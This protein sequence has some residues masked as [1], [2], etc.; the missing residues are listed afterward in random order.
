M[1]TTES[2]KK[3][4]FAP[5]DIIISEAE[6]YYASFPVPW[7]DN[8]E[9]AHL[10]AKE[11]VRV[12]RFAERMIPWISEPHTRW[13][14]ATL[15]PSSPEYNASEP[16]RVV[17]HAG[18]L[19]PGRTKSEIM[20]FW[21]R[22]ASDALGWR[23]KMGWSKEYED[24]LWSGTDVKSYQDSFLLWDKVREEYLR[25]VGHWHLAPLWV[26][27][28]HQ[29]RGVASLLLQDAIKL[30]EEENPVPPMYLEAMRDARPIYEHFG[31]QGVEGEGEKFAMI[32][33]PPEG[34]KILGEG[35]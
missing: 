27:P 23:E 15:S 14:K 1:A 31:Y 20:N 12:A 18:W 9:P 30:A 22:D 25:G 17:G 16:N 29:S 32:R 13:T 33:N 19:L 5:G 26:V 2:P 21:R 7:F 10:R 28:E 8:I 6:G 11:D 4:R 34:V 24:D 35:K 3:L